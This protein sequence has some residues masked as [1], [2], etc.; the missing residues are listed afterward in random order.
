MIKKIISYALCATTV[1]ALVGCNDATKPLQQ[2]TYPQYTD[3]IEL[4]GATTTHETSNSGHGFS[5]PALNLTSSQLEQHLAGDADFELSFTSAPNVQHPDMDGL[6]P[7]FNNVNCN[8]CHQRDGRPS[9]VVVAKGAAPVLLTHAAGIFLRISIEPS[10]QQCDKQTA[11]NNYCAPIAVPG[12]SDQLFHRGVLQA[13]HDWTSNPSIGQADV[14]LSYQY[15]DFTLEG[16]EIVT[17]KKPIFEVRNPYDAPNEVFNQG[18]NNSR[19][20]QDD[21]KFGAR[22]GM[23][24]FGLGLLE[25][26]AEQDILALADPDDSNKDGISGRANYVFDKI[27]AMANDPNPVS[28]GRFGWKANTPTVRQQSLGALRGDMGVT[29]PMFTQES[30]ARTPLHDDYLA[31]TNWQDTGS[32]SDGAPEASAQFSDDVTFYVETLAVPARR[33]IGDSEVRQ[34]AWLFEQLNCTGCHTPSFT[35]PTNIKIGG[36]DAIAALEQQTIY[37]FTDMLLHDMGEGLA[38]GRRDFLASGNE[39][40]TRP[41]WGIGLTRTVNP[42]AGWLHDGR[43]A[44]LEEAILWH[45][46]EALASQQQYKE[47]SKEDRAAVVSFLMSL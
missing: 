6:G 30:V 1:L 27:K 11:E 35:T 8:A 39:W 40:K 37:P 47:L 25:A 33:K 28:I 41:L 45:G 13:R 21:V 12:F 32:G 23:P 5:T 20:F 31:R 17:L 7:V 9:T 36:L 46:G 15:S 16:G 26:I 18:N 22:N 10:S 38:D 34:G 4:G 44:T 19:L 43:A 24:V 2:K 42:G 14:Y 29:N 3:V